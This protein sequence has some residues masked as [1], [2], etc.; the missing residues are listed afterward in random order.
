MSKKQWFKTFIIVILVVL[1]SACSK[2]LLPP[3]IET[4][5]DTGSMSDTGAGDA[6]GMEDTG[7]GSEGAASGSGALGGSDEPFAQEPQLERGGDTGPSSIFSESDVDASGNA[8]GG[9]GTGGLDSAGGDLSGSG[10]R[11]FGSGGNYE[12]PGDGYYGHYA[13]DKTGGFEKNA[14][15]I[16]T[17][18]DHVASVGGDTGSGN[19]GGVGN[20]GDLPISDRRDFGSGSGVKEP[21]DGYYGHGVGTPLTPLTPPGSSSSNGD[22]HANAG[23]TGTGGVRGNQDSGLGAQIR[24]GIQE[25][26]LLPFKSTADLKDVYFQFDKYGID[27]GSLNVLRQNAAI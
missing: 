3:E 15:D 21:G 27:S 20:G 12:I 22:H 6:G 16:P 9:T 17:G 24:E 11:G 5:S 4:V 7:S 26:R 8:I 14:E 13:S 19:N 10:S 1:T 2:K 18:S 25:A 23:D